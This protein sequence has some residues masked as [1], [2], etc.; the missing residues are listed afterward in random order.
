MTYNK[1]DTSNQIDNSCLVCGR[2]ATNLCSICR[3]ANYCCKEHQ[4]EDW[5]AHKQVCKD[6]APIVGPSL[7]PG[8]GNG[9]FAARDYSEGEYVCYYDG[10]IILNKDVKPHMNP[11]YMLRRDTCT[12]VGHEDPINIY[13]VGQIINDAS[14]MIFTDDDKSGC[15]NILQ[16][17]SDRINEKINDYENS[18]NKCN[19]KYDD[20]GNKL[21]ATRP[22]LAGQELY[23]HYGNNYW[24]SDAFRSSDDP[25]ERLF[26]L[27]L[28]KIINLIDGIF[29]FNGNVLSF[30]L[31]FDLLHL[32]P[33][34]TLITQLN[35]GH[36]PEFDQLKYLCD[37]II[38][39]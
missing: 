13:G 36:L 18:E 30:R 16:P 32:E 21:Y 20:V 35:I 29:Y 19:V 37:L 1:M 5:P 34:G 31:I 39:N 8:A 28:L 38:D 17:F 2:Y 25:M 14:T 26:F 6:G 24:Y 9:V 3:N 27:I 10:C 22:I 11:R 33:G 7:I 23:V 15:N 12:I 4:I